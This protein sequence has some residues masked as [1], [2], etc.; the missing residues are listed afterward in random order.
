DPLQIPAVQADIVGIGMRVSADVA[1][2]F[3]VFFVAQEN[4]S[5]AGETRE[6]PIEF[7]LQKPSAAEIYR[8]AGRSEFYVDTGMWLLS[9][10]AVEFLFRRCGW[11]ERRQAFATADGHPEYLDL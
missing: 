10:A 11:D 3:G 5:A 1:S 4:V 8:H 7:F 6:R 9:P 2:H